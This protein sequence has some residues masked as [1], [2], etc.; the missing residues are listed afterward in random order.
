MVGSYIINH[1]LPAIATNFSTCLTNYIKLVL[2]HMM[3]SSYVILTNIIYAFNYGLREH[4]QR[5]LLF[6][7]CIITMHVAVRVIIS[8][9]LVCSSMQKKKKRP[10]YSNINCT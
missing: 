1:D 4:F 6:A 3:L 10:N 2:T 8:A 9:L 5:G 7:H